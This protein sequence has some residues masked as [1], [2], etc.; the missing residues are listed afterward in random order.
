ML[1]PLLWAK[2]AR[3]LSAERVRSVAVRLIVERE[4]EI[5]AFIPE[6]F[7]D[8][9]RISF[10]GWRIGA[11]CPCSPGWQAVPSTSEKDTLARIEQCAKPNSRLPRGKINPQNHKPTAPFITLRFSRQ[12]RPIGV[13]GEEDHDHGPAAL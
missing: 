4:Q 6:E 10:S 3:G 12:P 7:W 8:V 2:I 11:F 13:F 5:R 9:L 1:S